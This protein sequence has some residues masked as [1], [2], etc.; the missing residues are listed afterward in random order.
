MLSGSI[1]LPIRHFSFE[2]K[3]S[4]I[5]FSHLIDKEVAVRMGIFEGR[6]ELKA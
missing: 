2:L 3:P 1:N 4:A 5:L 6:L